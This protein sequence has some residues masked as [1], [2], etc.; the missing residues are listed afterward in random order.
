MDG[1]LSHQLPSEPRGDVRD[2]LIYGLKMWVSADFSFHFVKLGLTLSVWL[3]E[4]SEGY[5]ASDPQYPWIGTR[6]HLS[7]PSSLSTPTQRHIIYS[8]HAA[9]TVDQLYRIAMAE[10]N[11]P[12]VLADATW[13]V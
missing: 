3:E 10:Q 5:L 8:T 6:L 9:P 11:T 2:L 13:C 1:R 7:R 12:P 4:S